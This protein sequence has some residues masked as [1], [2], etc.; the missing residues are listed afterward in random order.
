[1]ALSSA[2]VSRGPPAKRPRLE[3]EYVGAVDNHDESTDVD[4]EGG[5][6]VCDD[7]AAQLLAQQVRGERRHNEV[8]APPGLA[9]MPPSSHGMHA[10]MLRAHTASSPCSS[11]LLPCATARARAP[12]ALPLAVLAPHG[13]GTRTTTTPSANAISHA[14]QFLTDLILRVGG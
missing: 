1:M 12:A 13:A 2:W 8:R 9:L 11:N 5:D 14:P 4:I 6:G 3:Y 10:A 7:A